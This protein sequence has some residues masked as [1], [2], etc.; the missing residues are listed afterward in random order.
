MPRKNKYRP[1]IPDSQQMKLAP[2]VSGNTINGLDEEKVTKPKVV[3]WATEPNEIPHGKMQK[4]YVEFDRC[5]PFFN[6]HQGCGICIAVCPW[7]LPGVG[8]NLAE[9]LERKKN[10]V[11]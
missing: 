5:L 7:S 4:W 6:Q 3:Y 11:N 9:K 1:F 8:L 10:R 2:T